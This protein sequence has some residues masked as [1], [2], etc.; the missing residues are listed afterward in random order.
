[1]GVKIDAGGAVT[2]EAGGTISSNYYGV[3]LTGDTNGTVDNAGVISGRNNVGVAIEY[4]GQVTNESGG[5]ID[6]NSDGVVL[7]DGGMLTNAANATIIS[8]D[9]LGVQVEGAA[10]TIDNAG[11]IQG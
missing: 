5:T 11:L 10:G 9:A 1:Y 2:N 3:F 6:S 8:E 7:D 4:G